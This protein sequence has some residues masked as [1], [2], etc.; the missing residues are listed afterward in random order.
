MKEHCSSDSKDVV[1]IPEHEL[2]R[3]CI[4]WKQ[5]LPAPKKKTCIC[6]SCNENVKQLHNA[7]DDVAKR[8][9][10]SFNNAVLHIVE[11]IDGN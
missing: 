10:T 5:L 6:P 2:D 3:V 9:Q 1:T 4:F 8:M 11:A 7:V